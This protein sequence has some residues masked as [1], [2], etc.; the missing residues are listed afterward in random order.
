MIRQAFGV[1]ACVALV[2]TTLAAVE[3]IEPDDTEANERL[4]QVRHALTVSIPSF[5]LFKRRVLA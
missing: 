4:E 1:L 5:P 2:S 3:E